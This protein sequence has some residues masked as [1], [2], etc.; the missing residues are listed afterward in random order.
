MFLPC[1]QHGLHG[2]DES[3][4]GLRWWLSQIQVEPRSSTWCPLCQPAGKKPTEQADSSQRSSV[5]RVPFAKQGHEEV[6]GGF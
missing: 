3:S 4:V 6:P 2:S 5:T 1:A